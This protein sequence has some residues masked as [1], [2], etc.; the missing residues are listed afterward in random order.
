MDHQASSLVD[1]TASQ[2]SEH[3]DRVADEKATAH[4]YL[5]IDEVTAM[6]YESAYRQRHPVKMS[7]SLIHYTM[8]ALN[9]IP[10][11]DE[12]TTREALK[13]EDEDKC[14]VA[15]STELIALQSLICWSISEP[16]ASTGTLQVKF[17]FIKQP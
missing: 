13:C 8:N 5:I 14:H 2:T 9:C 6:Y 12:S 11:T 17:V 10:G 1:I 15:M 7:E 3:V 16:F 4:L